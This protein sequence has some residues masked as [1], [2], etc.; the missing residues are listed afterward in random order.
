MVHCIGGLVEAAAERRLAQVGYPGVG[1]VPH[2]LPE[3]FLDILCSFEG[4]GQGEAL[5]LGQHKQL[6]AGEDAQKHR[7]ERDESRH[8]FLVVEEH[9]APGEGLSHG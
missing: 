8:D 4:D 2:A 9:R 1:M 3:P 5:M 7:P 6:E